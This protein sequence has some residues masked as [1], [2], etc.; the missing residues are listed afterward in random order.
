MTHIS[1]TIKTKADITRKFIFEDADI[2]GETVGLSKTCIDILANHQYAPSVERLLC[3]FMSA[4]TLLSTTIKFEGLLILQARSEG[5][6]P[7][8]MAECSSQRKVRAIARGAELASSDHFQTLLSNG[9]LAITMKAMIAVDCCFNNCLRKLNKILSSGLISGNTSVSWQTLSAPKS[10]LNWTVQ[11]C[12]FGSTTKKKC[13]CLKPATLNSS[14]VAAGNAAA[15]RWL[16]CLARSLLTCWKNKVK[17]RSIV[18]SVTTIT[19]LALKKFQ[20][21]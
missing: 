5:E 7:I 9:Q 13:A 21:W 11:I 17:L 8:I 19:S 1:K 10:C 18:S 14:A 2:R 12:Y 15:Q 3:E 6:I 4:A 20:G 16:R